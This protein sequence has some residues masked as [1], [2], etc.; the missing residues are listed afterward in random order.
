[1]TGVDKRTRK[2]SVVEHSLASTQTQN[3]RRKTM[4]HF[5]SV[6]L[7]YLLLQTQAKPA[8]GDSKPDRLQRLNC[9][10]AVLYEQAS[11]E[12]GQDFSN[13]SHYLAKEKNAIQA[14]VTAELMRVNLAHRQQFNAVFKAI[15]DWQPDQKSQP[16]R[17]ALLDALP[18]A[19]QKQQLQVICRD[20]KEHLKGEIVTGLKDSHPQ[21]Y[22][23]LLG[24]HKIKGVPL[25][26]SGKLPQQMTQAG[27][28]MDRFVANHP[29]GV[30][31]GS[32]SL[33]AAIKKYV[34]VNTLVSTLTTPQPVDQQLQGFKQNFQSQSKIIEKDRDGWGMKFIKG[35]ATVLSLGIAWACGIWDVK[36]QK[37]AEKMTQ[38]LQ[39]PAPI[40]GLG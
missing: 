9:H 8:L 36:G 31:N 38:T 11:R 40:P 35:V 34:A 18:K 13:Q 1:L 7:I 29:Q 12:G 33:N 21:E 26:D 30:L 17:K 32:D 39:P 16:V 15:E 25:P 37:A 3:K 20:Y 27:G 19:R 22:A 28:N 2:I 24:N 6:N 14:R 5:N 23:Q 10:A 4:R